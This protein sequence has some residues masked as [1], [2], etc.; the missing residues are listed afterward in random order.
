MLRST[1]ERILIDYPTALT[2]DF[3]GNPTV[4]FIR[5]K[6]PKDLTEALPPAL[7]HFRCIGSGGAGNFATVPWL[8]VF[9]PLVTNS[10][11][12]GYYEVV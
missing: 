11:T 1:L 6:A 10:A 12:Q 8:A 7:S 3:A 9:D 4:S 2:E 5:N